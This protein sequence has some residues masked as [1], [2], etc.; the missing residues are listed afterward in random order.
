MRVY[1]RN[2]DTGQ[3]MVV[4]T[5]AEGQ[6]DYVYITAMIQCI[7]LSINESPFWADWGIPAQQSVVQQI[8]PDFYVTLIQQRY[9][10][11]F[12]RLQITKLQSSTPTYNVEVVTNQGVALNMSVAV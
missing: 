9:A 7:K 8:F 2:P 5:T 1:G 11:F 3:W 10:P 12:S 6:D 4:Q